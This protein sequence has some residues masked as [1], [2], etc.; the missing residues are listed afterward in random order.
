MICPNC[1]G[2]IFVCEFHPDKPWTPTLLGQGQSCQCGADM[3]CPVCR[4]QLYPMGSDEAFAEAVH[5]AIEATAKEMR[6]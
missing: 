5:E 2:A 1:K 6:F 4:P 3:P